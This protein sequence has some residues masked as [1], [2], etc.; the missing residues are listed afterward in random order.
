VPSP[1]AGPENVTAGSQPPA[2]SDAQAAFFAEL[3]PLVAR[4]NARLAALRDEVAGLVE[5]IDNGGTLRKAH[6]QRLGELARRYRVEGD[7]VASPEARREL[8]RK[9]DIVPVS[10]ALAQAANE[11]AWG[12]SRFA[13]EGNNLF[14]IWTYDERQGIVPRKRSPGKK[15][16]VRRFDSVADS[17][18]YYMHTLNSHPAYAELRAIRAGLREDGRSP[19]GHSLADGLTRYSAKGKDYV[20]TIRAMIRRFDLAAFDAAPD[21]EA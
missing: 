11:S 14:G 10:L 18:R 5:T 17:V 4:E 15:H 19:D 16:L 2:G 1:A 3:Q 20:H 8:L 12:K 21:R 13:R 7:P 9:V 6:R